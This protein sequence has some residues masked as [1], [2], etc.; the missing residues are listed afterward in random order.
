MARTKASE[1]AKYENRVAPP[2]GKCRRYR[3]QKKLKEKGQ[4]KEKRINKTKQLANKKLKQSKEEA[5]FVYNK[6]CHKGSKLNQWDPVDMKAACEQLA[7]LLKLI[8]F[9]NSVNKI[10]CN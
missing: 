5:I 3:K 10:D 7:F 1:R 9:K 8:A 4:P 2:T 6:K